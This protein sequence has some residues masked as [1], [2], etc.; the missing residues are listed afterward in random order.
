M[1]DEELEIR[2]NEN[3][4]RLTDTP[5]THNSE[6]LCGQKSPKNA[7]KVPCV[8]NVLYREP[9]LGPDRF[10]VVIFSI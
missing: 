2:I 3:W 9:N 7:H 10:P 1:A 4:A 5:E 6:W 8:S